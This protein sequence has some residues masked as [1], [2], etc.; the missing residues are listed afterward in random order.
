ML[1]LVDPGGAGKRLQGLIK[2]QARWGW[3]FTPVASC[4]LMFS[5]PERCQVHAAT[6]Q[7]RRARFPAYSAPHMLAI[8]SRH[9]REPKQRLQG[10]V[11]T[12]K[13]NLEKRSLSVERQHDGGTFFRT[14]GCFGSYG[15]QM[16]SRLSGTAAMIFPLRCHWSAFRR[17][18]RLA[19]R[20]PS[21]ATVLCFLTLLLKYPGWQS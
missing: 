13:R 5:L 16:A 11:E 7:R 15:E 17:G 18:A 9:L 2:P 1:F 3:G 8:A 20:R 14:L 12:F 6:G 10:A 19:G 4:T 21:S